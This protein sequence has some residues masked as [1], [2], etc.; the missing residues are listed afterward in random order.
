MLLSA[1]LNKN[2]QQRLQHIGDMRLFLDQTLAAPGPQTAAAPQKQSSR[3]M[4]LSAVLGLA[5]I[6]ALIP[7]VLYF[8]QAPVDAPAM[9]FETAIPDLVNAA[10][11]I[12]PDGRQVAYIVQSAEGQR[13][14]WVRP[15]GSEIAQ[16]VKGTEGAGGVGW[17]PDS[18]HLGFTA[19]GKFKKID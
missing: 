6:V 16:Q 13:S 19:E 10:F 9:R 11:S 8:R 4:L 18:K 7:A 2:P 12:S 5:L 14:V 17:S 15:I 1:T 3:G